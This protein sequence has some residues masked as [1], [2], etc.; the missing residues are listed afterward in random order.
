MTWSK[1]L[2][3]YIMNLPLTRLTFV[4]DFHVVLGML[5][6]FDVRESPCVIR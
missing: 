2:S 4:R 3:S 6:A 5:P 1:K